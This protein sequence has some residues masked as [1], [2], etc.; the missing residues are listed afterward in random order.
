MGGVINQNSGNYHLWRNSGRGDKKESKK[1]PPEEQ[2]GQESLEAWKPRE[3]NVQGE[4][5]AVPWN[6]GIH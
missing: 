3:G 6:L 5:H 2:R 4:Q 1:E